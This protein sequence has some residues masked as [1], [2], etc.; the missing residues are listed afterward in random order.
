M[1]RY[2]PKGISL[3]WAIAGCL[4]AGLFL[5]ILQL[6][7]TG[8]LP[9]V[10]ERIPHYDKIGHVFLFAL[11]TYLG[12]RILNF[13]CITLFNRHIPLWATLFG[14]FTMVEEGIQA[15]SPNRTFSLADLVCSVLGIVVGFWLAEQGRAKMEP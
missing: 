13:R 8:N 2:L 7:Y 6:A 9:P 3:G 15:F 12:Q 1:K 14:I 5:I 10:L 4:Y 11:A